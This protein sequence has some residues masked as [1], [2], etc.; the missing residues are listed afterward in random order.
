MKKAPIIRYLIICLTAVFFS[1]EKNEPGDTLREGFLSFSSSGQTILDAAINFSR[2]QVTFEVEPDADITRLVPEFTVPPGLTVYL[3]GSEQV[4]GNSVVDFSQPVRYELKNTIGQTAEW[5]AEAVPVSKR[6][7]ID[8]S[9]DGGVWW[10]P[11]YE[12]TGFDQ[13]KAHQ[14]KKFADML[15]E[16]GFRVDE[17]GRDAELKEE[18]FFGYFIVIRVNGFQSY[19]PKELDVYTKLVKR[20]MNMVFFT[21]HK[22]NDREDE[23][24]DLLGLK[25]EGVANGT[26]SKF[27][28]HMITDNLKDLKYLDG[29]ERMNMPTLISME[30]GMPQNR[31][32]LPSWAY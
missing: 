20:G 25:F 26:I 24:G 18:H 10:F 29:S 1:C 15:R 8:A 2:Q 3:N 28:K 32:L 31:W 13:G 7:V 27:S 17:L 4:S 12:Y 23:L 5:N 30:Y 16:K 11:Q 19:T 14:G 9:H 22:K 21:D 6:I